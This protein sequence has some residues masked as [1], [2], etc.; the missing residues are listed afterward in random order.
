MLLYDAGLEL[1]QQ[2][3]RVAALEKSRP[4]FGRFIAIISICLVAG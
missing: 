1:G 2:I 3:S 4:V